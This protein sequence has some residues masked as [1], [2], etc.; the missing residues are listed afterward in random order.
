MSADTIPA[1][2]NFGDGY[3]DLDTSLKLVAYNPTLHPGPWAL[4]LAGLHESYKAYDVSSACSAEL[5][6]ETPDTSLFFLAE[7]NDGVPVGGIRFA[8]PLTGLDQSATL[9]EMSASPEIDELRAAIESQI[10]SGVIEIKGLWSLGSSKIGASL[11]QAL[12]RTL[13]PAFVLLSVSHAYASYADRLTP[14]VKECGPEKVYEVP[15][16]YPDERYATVAVHFAADSLLSNASPASLAAYKAQSNVIPA[17]RALA[18][19]IYRPLILD[20]DT[21][22]TLLPSDVRV[23]DHLSPQL[24]QLAELHGLSQSLLDEPAR[25]VFYPWNNTALKLLGPRSFATLRLARNRNKI[26]RAEQARLRSRRVAVV[27][28]SAGHAIA[29]TIAQEGLAAALRLAD[30]DT[31]ELSNLNR[32]PATL[33]DLGLN[34]AVVLA[35]RIAELD[36]YLDIDIFSSGVDESTI[37]AFLHNIDVVVEECDSIDIKVLVR[38]RAR[39]MGIPVLMETSDRG[40]LDVERFDLEPNRPLFHGRLG[41]VAASELKGLSLADRGPHAVRIMSPET[42]SPRA[43]AS[44]LELDR[45]LTGWPQLGG[46]IALGAATIAAALRR[47]GS[48]NDLSSGRVQVDLDTHLGELSE[49]PYDPT[50]MAGLAEPLPKDPEDPELS[51]ELSVVDAA[52]RA[53]SGG[54]AQPWNFSIKH[55]ILEVFTA[56]ELSAN[57]MD[58]RSRGTFVAAGAALLNARVRASALG[59]LGPV[60]TFP[61][62]LLSNKVATM[63]F[64]NDRDPA[65]TALDPY[66]TARATN[67]RIAPPTPWNPALSPA[68]VDA[69]AIEG[70]TLRLITERAPLDSFAVQIAEADQLRF[71]LPS[72]HESMMKELSWP[73]R[74]DLHSGLDVRT[75]EMD[76]MSLASL[77]VLS[78][79]DVLDELNS[80]KAGSVLAARTQAAINF[81]S[82]LAVFSVTR[83]GPRGYLRGGQALER[84]W[85]TATKLGIA[86]QPV[87]P[88]F[89]YADSEDDLLTLGGI[90]RL[91]ELQARQARFI[92][93]LDLDDTE[94]LIMVLR[95][96]YAPPPSATS[97]KRPLSSVLRD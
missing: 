52:R 41:N 45:T 84:T 64:G 17:E 33:A 88:L 54:N 48:P 8:G 75:L 69:A 53:P 13:S 50:L 49:A 67:R 97:I 91:D 90:R 87:S 4:Y 51:P 79:R 61:A 14:L 40:T 7:G 81:S 92:S 80:W 78:R 18:D 31:I 15:V 47:L 30:F 94:V 72:V 63:A 10:S 32:I 34:K 70:V 39:A 11:T 76:A 77:Q 35:R 73:G 28:A 95:L 71:L 56:P 22:L 58:I 43:L 55:N 3:V 6:G 21:D 24:T 1:K 29:Y 82:A 83:D 65:L 36:P 68:L 23:I 46:D 66:I 16:P 2:I 38:E 85:L 20:L 5:L 37:D 89:L 44:L 12:V 62:G 86:V 42:L 9:T 60:T 25:L 26:T 93:E 27:G 57:A 74:D 59:I 19:T 96:F